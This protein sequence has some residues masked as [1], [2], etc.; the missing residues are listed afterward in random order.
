[1]PYNQDSMDLKRRYNVLREQNEKLQGSIKVL[2]ATIE[3]LT[4]SQEKTEG[5]KNRYKKAFEDVFVN[6]IGN[7]WEKI[8][9]EQKKGMSLDEKVSFFNRE[10]N[11]VKLYIRSRM[12]EM[13]MELKEER[14]RLKKE[15]E[16]LLKELQHINEKMRNMELKNE[17]KDKAASNEADE[18]ASPDNEHSSKDRGKSTG[19]NLMENGHG[20]KSMSSEV[21]GALMGLLP[22]SGEKP[23]DEKKVSAKKAVS[24]PKQNTYIPS[25]D[26]QQAK[27]V[28][29]WSQFRCTPAER[30]QKYMAWFSSVD[31][32]LDGISYGN[33][34]LRVIGSTGKYKFKDIFDEGVRRN[35]WNNSDENRIRKCIQKIFDIFDGQQPL[36]TKMEPPKN[37]GQGGTFIVYSLTKQGQA[38]YA[39]KTTENP[40]ESLY[41]TGTDEQKSPGHKALIDQIAND[42]KNAGFDVYTEVPEA[43]TETGEKSIAD[44]VAHKGEVINIR[45]ECEMGNYN[46]DDYM[47]KFRKVLEVTPRLIV[48]VPTKKEQSHI[49][50]VIGKMMYTYYGGIDNFRK[51]GKETI[52]LTAGEI[53]KNPDLVLPRP[54]S[55]PWGK[56]LM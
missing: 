50:E 55:K 45:I 20:K 6:N 1:M 21:R 4:V 24:Q 9:D 15:N 14:N 25:N 46:D 43:T 56:K 13:S 38:W 10:S 7:A 51:E 12:D 41:Q 29:W 18:D 35:F 34:V 16:E 52:V 53:H 54:T 30:Q 27:A 39:L 11:M 28:D 40:V 37:Y 8:P 33:E 42:L 44:I 17:V 49:R 26:A 2:Q 23:A 48:A 32:L 22:N 47:Y 36:I 19:V 5:E 31:S 3:D